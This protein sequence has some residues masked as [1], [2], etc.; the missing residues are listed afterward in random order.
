MPNLNRGQLYE[1]KI[2]EILTEQ[3]ILPD[4]LQ[5]N[6][7]GFLFPDNKILICPT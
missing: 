5:S 7:A 3:G 2:R 1:I 6:D 4:D